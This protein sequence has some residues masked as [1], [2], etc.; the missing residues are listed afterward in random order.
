[1]ITAALTLLGLAVLC[2]GYRTLSGP[3]LAD[4][5]IGISGMLTA[6]MATVV[7]QAVDSDSGAFLPV[8]VVVSLVGFVG[9][10]M[11]ARFIERQG[12]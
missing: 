2:F 4:R 3:T 11:V 7:V 9:T 5:M 6:G 8:L 12:R 1:M 10:G